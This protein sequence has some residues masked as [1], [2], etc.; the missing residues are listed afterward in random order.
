MAMYMYSDSEYHYYGS[1][2]NKPIT[3]TLVVARDS[4]G[5]ITFKHEGKGI[6]RSSAIQKMLK[7]WA[8]DTE[9]ERLEIL[10]I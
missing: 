7:A 4:R 9:K 6:L 10:Y 8:V 5:N 2:M 3:R 1:V